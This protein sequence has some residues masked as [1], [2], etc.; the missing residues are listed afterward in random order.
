MIKKW[1]LINLMLIM[2]LKQCNT[3]NKKN[4]VQVNPGDILFSFSLQNDLNIDL[5][6]PIIKG[7]YYTNKIKLYQKINDDYILFSNNLLAHPNGYAIEVVNC[8][9][10]F[11]PYYVDQKTENYHL[12]IDWGNGRVDYITANCITEKGNLKTIAQILYNNTQVWH[13]NHHQEDRF[14][15]IIKN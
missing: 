15:V 3:G 8:I 12:K 5:L 7:S 10:R 6:N 11:T 13:K 14:F 1:I 4:E 2:G 9:Y